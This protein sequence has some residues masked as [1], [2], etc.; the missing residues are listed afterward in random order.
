MSHTLHLAKDFGSFG[1]DFSRSVKQGESLFSRVLSI[2]SVETVS[3]PAQA[4][5][6]FVG[7]QMMIAAC[8]YSRVLYYMVSILFMNL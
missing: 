7:N 4:C 6:A 8:V 2:T 3:L 5:V 1:A